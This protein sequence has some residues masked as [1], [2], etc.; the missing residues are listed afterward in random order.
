VS[1]DQ[2]GPL[3]RVSWIYKFHQFT[4]LPVVADAALRRADR[5]A[6][7]FQHNIV[8]RRQYPPPLSLSFHAACARAASHVATV[9]PVVITSYC[10]SFP[11]RAR[12][13]I[14]RAVTS[15]A[16]L[17]A[18]P[19]N[20]ALHG[21][22]MYKSPSLF[23]AFASAVDHREICPRTTRARQQPSGC[24]TIVRTALRYPQLQHL[25]FCSRSVCVPRRTE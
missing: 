13:G 24:A 15:R 19:V 18:R 8:Q 9:T 4:G 2:C 21:V 25:Q 17:V 20:S 10:P 16:A 14:H 3:Y 11:F 6:M 7:L 23:V 22:T 5:R 12:H 1:V